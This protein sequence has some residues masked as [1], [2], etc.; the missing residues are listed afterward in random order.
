MHDRQ[1]TIRF[2]RWSGSRS[3]SRNFN[4]FCYHG[5]QLGIFA[6]SC[7]CLGGGL[8]SPNG[9]SFISCYYERRKQDMQW[10]GGRLG[11]IYAWYKIF[12]NRTSCA[13]GRH[14]MSPPLQVDLWPFDLESGVTSHVPPPPVWPHLF[15]GAGHEK[16]GES[17][18][19][20]PWHLG[21]TSE[22]SFSMCTATRTSSYSPVGPSVF[23]LA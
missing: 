22:V 20:G 6:R 12:I 2:W 21:C 23:Y 16:G 5:G 18:W 1:Q 11:C 7:S 3:G 13:G 4:G 8:Q 15:C 14:N 10:G 19:S 17:S 9:L